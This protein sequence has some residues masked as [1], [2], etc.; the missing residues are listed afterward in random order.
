MRI[1]SN[2]GRQKAGRTARVD[3]TQL[4]VLGCGLLDSHTQ[5]AES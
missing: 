5:C 1:V 2:S 3:S 4:L